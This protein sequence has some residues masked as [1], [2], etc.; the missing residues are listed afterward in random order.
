M[1]SKAIILPLLGLICSLASCGE[2]DANA[3]HYEID[4]TEYVFPAITPFDDSSLPEEPSDHFVV[5]CPVSSGFNTYY[6]WDDLGNPAP[7]SW[8]GTEMASFY[9][10]DWYKVEVAD[11]NLV[12]V[13]FNNNGSPQTADMKMTHFGYWWYWVSDSSLHDEKPVSSWIDKA[14]FVDEDTISIVS[15][16]D[17]SQFSFYEGEELLLSGSPNKQ[18]IKIELGNHDFD[19]EKGYKVVATTSGV[20]MEKE[21]QTTP[22]YRLDAFNEK[23]AYYGDDLGAS[24]SSSSTTFKVWSPFSS[25]IKLNIYENGTPSSIDPAKG[26][27]EKATYSMSKGEKGVFSYTLKGDLDG[28]YYTYSVTNSTYENKEIVDP[29]AKAVGVNGKR[30][31]IIDLTKTNPEGWDEIK[32]LEYDRKEL[33]VWECH[34]ADL[35]SSSL[36]NGTESN[37]LKYAGF[38][39]SGTSYTKGDVTVKTG[40]DHVKELGVNAV[41]ILPMFD[42]D[43]NETVSAF[44]WGYNPLNYNAP[45][46]IYSSDPYHGEVRIKELKSLIMDYNLAGISIIMDVVYNHVAGASQSNFDVLFPGYYFRYSEKGVLLNGSGCGNE[47]ASDHYMFSKF[48]VDSA[49]YWAKEYKL[50]GFRFDLMGL[51]DLDTMERLSASCKAINPNIVIYGEPWD[52]GSN[53]LPESERAIQKNGESYVGYGQFN[54]GLRDALIK[55]GLNA[56]ASTGWSSDIASSHL[57]DLKALKGGVVGYTLSSG[58][59]ED[60][61]KTVNYVTCHD[62][63]TLYDRLAYNWYSRKDFRPFIDKMALLSDAV[64]FTSLGTSFML[65]GDEFLRSKDMDHNSY[66]SSYKINE[67]DWELKAD[68][69][70]HFEL[71]KQ[72]IALKQSLEGLHGDKEAAS[73]IEV[74][75]SSEGNLIY[76][77]IPSNGKTYRIAHCAGWEMSKKDGQYVLDPEPID[78]S[79]FPN[80]VFNDG[81]DL[82]LSSSTKLNAFQTIVASE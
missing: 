53:G 76:Y 41:Q 67:L 62:N 43:N 79:A 39:E 80:I 35:T 37:R 42:Q 68:N 46:G 6:G 40:F 60:P 74:H 1:K 75:S 19:L 34:I 26:S 27:D 7:V 59:V 52:A 17:I 61:D 29:Y 57:D 24:Y 2:K 65:S 5:F 4:D 31:E 14:T 36:W 3:I 73:K 22:L 23:Y 32:P 25:E 82:I 51:H 9:D 45:D 78:F 15:S 71:V 72:M 10:K 56:A 81:D 58:T 50:G 28:K 70:A 63:Y 64:V 21:V 69:L 13:I 66:Q 33:T 44:N 8:P 30:G 47:T 38:H 54:D 49:S 77:D 55:G 48:M 18:A 16:G 20:T 11:P 12:N